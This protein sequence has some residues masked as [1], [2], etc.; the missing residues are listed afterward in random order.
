MAALI[1]EKGAAFQS[2]PAGKPSGSSPWYLMTYDF[3][4]KSADGIAPKPMMAVTEDAWDTTGLGWS[5]MA[6]LFGGER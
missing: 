2:Q 3:R 1:A 4:V 5:V 6:P